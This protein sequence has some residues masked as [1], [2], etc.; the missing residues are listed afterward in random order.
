MI[1]QRAELVSLADRLGAL[2]LVRVVM[3]VVVLGAAL[4]DVGQLGLSPR[5]VAFSTISMG[6]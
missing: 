5:S 3:A 4:F 6:N 2:Q 1:I